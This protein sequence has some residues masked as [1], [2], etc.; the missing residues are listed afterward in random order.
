[1]SAGPK[2]ADINF[3]AAGSRDADLRA[4]NRSA[5]KDVGL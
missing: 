3:S 2:K 1:M 5:G 4:T